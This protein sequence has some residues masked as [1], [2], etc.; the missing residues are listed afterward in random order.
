[1]IVL[2]YY[3]FCLPTRG[4][5]YL[6]QSQLPIYTLHVLIEMNNLCTQQ[7]SGNKMDSSNLATVFG[8]NVLRR[9]KTGKCQIDSIEMAQNADIVAIVKDLIDFHAAVFR[10][11]GML[12]LYMG[13][14]CDS[15]C[16]GSSCDTPV[17]ITPV[18]VPVMI[19]AV[20]H[21]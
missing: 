8:P 13:Y 18:I 17:M 3:N 19:A 7:A 9:C 21:L 16:H 5:I 11:R 2:S 20:T 4:V 1:M 10:V 15:T 12:V 14:T 6:H